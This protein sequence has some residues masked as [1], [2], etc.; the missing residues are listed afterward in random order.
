MSL[1]LVVG[2]VEQTAP[3]PVPPGLSASGDVRSGGQPI[4]GATVTAELGGKKLVTVTDDSG[5]YVLDGMTPGTWTLEVDMFGFATAKRS[6]EAGASV[7]KVDW[8]L[9]LKAAATRV[10]GRGA[11]GTGRGGTRGGAGFQSLGSQADTQIDAAMA[12]DNGG[13]PPPGATSGSADVALLVNGSLTEG[14]QNTGSPAPDQ[15]GGRERFGRGGGGDSGGTPP[16]FGGGDSGGGGRGGFG[17]GGFRGGGG[18]GGGDRSQRRGRPGSGEMIGNRANRGRDQIHGMASF[19]LANSA[20]NAKPFSLTGQDVIEPSNAQSRISVVVGGALI[21][22]KIV[23]SP[24]TFFFISYFATRARNPYKNVASTA[25]A[26]ERG[27]DFS[28]AG[29]SIYDAFTGVPFAGNVIPKSRISPIALGLLNYIPL[30]NQPG[31]VQNYQIL[32]SV[33][34]NSDN[35]GLRLNQNVTRRDRLS[36]NLQLQRRANQNSQLFGY[37][38]ELSGFGANVTVGYTRNIGVRAINSAQAQFNRNRSNT[39]PFFAN[40]ANVAQELGIQGTSPNP[41]DFGPPNLSFTNF[42]ALSDGTD[43]LVRSQ[44]MGGTE[45]FSVPIHTHNLSFGAN[46]TRSQLNTVTDQN[47]RGAFTFT[48]LSTSALD[49][50]GSPIAGTGF[51]FADF[52]LGLP[53]TSSIRYGTSATYFRGSVV[54]LFGQDDWRILPNL[55]LNAGLR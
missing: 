38:D 18:R 41:I 19:S 48:G 24:N 2:G 22:P 23:K 9:D 50:N 5:H 20:V 14:L 16:G 3:V 52:L 25:T 43:S 8:N 39:T 45:S 10:A 49:A 15:G 37:R 27:G 51:D 44:S 11:A 53:Q 40:K 32:A 26:A 6:V 28:Q 7:A 17:G 35:F 36:L 13:A 55:S 33:P 4:P 30:P 47:G 42:G 12:A 34:Q 46:F 31:T 1:T 54:G 21:I 29:V